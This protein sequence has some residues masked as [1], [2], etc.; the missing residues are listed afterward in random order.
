[1]ATTP[2]S[3]VPFS[4]YQLFS[5]ISIFH[6]EQRTPLDQSQ[7]SQACNPVDRSSA[8]I[9]PVSCQWRIRRRRTRRLP[10]RPHVL[11]WIRSCSCYPSHLCLG[12]CIC[13]DPRR[14]RQFWN[15]SCWSNLGWTCVSA[16]PL[17]MRK[18]LTKLQSWHDQCYRS[19]ISVR[20]FS[21][22]E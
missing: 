15:V 10:P 8:D 16:D 2:Q 13:C 19:G 12:R 17:M 9:Y 22:S 11:E 6:S 4:V 14:R 5:H 3:S 1:M 18:V 21:T 20:D 7:V